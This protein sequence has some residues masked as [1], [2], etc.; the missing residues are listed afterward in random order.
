[1]NAVRDTGLG[2]ALAAAFAR[3]VDRTGVAGDFAAE[4]SAASF[5]DERAETVF[6]MAEEVLRNV[7]R[8]AQAARVSVRLQMAGAAHLRLAIEDDGTGFDPE[9]PQP[10]HFGLVGLREQAQLIGAE[11]LIDSAPGRGTR[12]LVTVRTAPVVI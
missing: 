7:E 1:V 3:F 2:P 9:A 10:G 8:H 12:V 5:G 6:R 4:P 11:L